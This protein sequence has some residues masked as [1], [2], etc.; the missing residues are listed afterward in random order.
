MLL[1]EYSTSRLQC[2]RSQMG[3]YEPMMRYSL[4]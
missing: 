4:F 3:H 1:F 2:V